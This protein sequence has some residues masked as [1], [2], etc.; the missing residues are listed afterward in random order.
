MTPK[1]LRWQITAARLRRHARRLH[2]TLE[3]RHNLETILNHVLS[4][5]IVEWT[6]LGD[7]VDDERWPDEHE[8][9][10]GAV[11]ANLELLLEER[12][13]LAFFGDLQ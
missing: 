4:C 10:V 1:Y 6:V 2:D 9:I 12:Q 3:H 7:L 8:S 11:G 5:Q 13:Q